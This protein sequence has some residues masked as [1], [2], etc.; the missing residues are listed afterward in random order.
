MHQ[1]WCIATRAGS[2]ALSNLATAHKAMAH[3]QCQQL[4][5]HHAEHLQPNAIELVKAGPGA[6]LR[7]ATEELRHELQAAA[8]PSGGNTASKYDHMDQTRWSC[9][10]HDNTTASTIL[11]EAW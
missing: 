6:T 9:D 10:E 11:L 2:K 1:I 3:L 7:K 8:V 4:L 5:R